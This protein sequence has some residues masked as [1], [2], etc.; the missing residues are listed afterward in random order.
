LKGLRMKTEGS[1]SLPQMENIYPHILDLIRV[2]MEARSHTQLTI[3]YFFFKYINEVMGS[4]P[5]NSLLQ[6]CWER[7]C[8]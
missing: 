2:Q 5:G 7:L 4:G 6:K 3:L 8:T 1:N